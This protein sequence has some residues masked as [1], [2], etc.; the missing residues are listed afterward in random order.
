M[1][2]RACSLWCA[3]SINSCRRGENEWPL[4]RTRWTRF[5]LNPDDMSLSDKP[6][7]SENKL[8]Y[9]ALGD[10]LTF[11]SAPLKEETEFTGP[12]AAKLFVSSATKDADI[13]VDLP[14]VRAGRQR[15]RVSRRDR[16]AHAGRARLAARLASQARSAAKSTPY[17]PYHTHDEV[18]PLTPGKPVE[19]DVEIWPTSI[20]VPAGY[21]VA[22]TLR[23]ERLRISGA[24][25]GSAAAHARNQGC[26][27]FLSR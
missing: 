4:A 3:T 6:A 27:P 2:S 7:H 14:R 24:R 8:E 18:Q 25:N 9:E 5:Y 21:R 23:G 1:P 20:V 12:S 15:S 22:F 16:S 10:G 13:F 17:R 11:M 26:G 19:L